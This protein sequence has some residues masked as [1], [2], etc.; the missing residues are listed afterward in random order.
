MSFQKKSF[1]FF[2]KM[3]DNKDFYIFDYTFPENKSDIISIFKKFKTAPKFFEYYTNKDVNLIFQTLEKLNIIYSKLLKENNSYNFK[4]KIDIYISDLSEIFL[5][6]NLISENKKILD[7]VIIQAR[8][9][10]DI[11]YFSNQINKNNQK[12]INNYVLNL[13]GTENTENKNNIHSLFFLND[14]INKSNTFH[15][16]SS[17]IIFFN[18]KY[19]NKNTEIK[20]IDNSINNS[21]LNHEITHDITNHTNNNN[22]SIEDNVFI[23]FTTPQFPGRI[24]DN[25]NKY[26]IT[27]QNLNDDNNGNLKNN[28]I[29]QESL[30]SNDEELNKN[31]SKKE[32]I[33]SLYTLA[34][35]SKFICQEEKVKGTSSKFKDLILEERYNEKRR[36]SIHHKKA[37]SRF[38]FTEYKNDINNIN[39]NIEDEVK[40]NNSNKKTFSSSNLKTSKEKKMIKDLLVYVNFLYKKEIINFDEKIKLKVLIISKCEKLQNLYLIYYENNK[41]ILIKELKKLIN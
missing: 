30:N 13:L 15:N 41:D 2:G 37:S 4:S 40:I 19:D 36:N 23:D 32:S 14:K 12:K 34:S 9:N 21:S 17:N 6:F 16:K 38:Q 35:K 3:N 1:D 22:N 11:F 5:L 24:I 29:K 18:E 20:I 10:L 8:K 39:K 26:I 7:K 25:N 33:R 28:I 27:E 31:Y